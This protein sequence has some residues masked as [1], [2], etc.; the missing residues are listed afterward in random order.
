MN[1][2]PINNYPKTFK[3][4]P[5]R[6]IRTPDTSGANEPLSNFFPCTLHSQGQVFH[7]AEQ[8]IH[9]R[10]VRMMHN[11]RAVELIMWAHDGPTF[12]TVA[13]IEIPRAD[14][15]WLQHICDIVGEVAALKLKQCAQFRDEL[16]STQGQNIIEDTP[17]PFRGRGPDGQGANK[18]GELLE[19]VRHTMINRNDYRPNGEYRNR[20]CQSCGEMHHE[21]ERCRYRPLLSTDDDRNDGW[22]TYENRRN[23]RRRQRDDHWADPRDEQYTWRCQY[24]AE[25]GHTTDRCRHG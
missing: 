12:H 17:D 25:T 2:D 13:K 21:N 24:C 14:P 23:R 8:L 22:T 3:D 11:E 9:F 15:R 20:C 19:K 16:L 10:R 7:S 4:L 1:N 5:H 18:M 6:E